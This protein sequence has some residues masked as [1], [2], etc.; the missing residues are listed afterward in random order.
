MLIGALPVRYVHI[1][2]FRFAVFLHSNPCILSYL[3][4]IL[5]KVKGVTENPHCNVVN[6][7]VI[8]GPSISG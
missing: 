5:V 8:R 2:R 1:L 7:V 6:I 4:S 3:M